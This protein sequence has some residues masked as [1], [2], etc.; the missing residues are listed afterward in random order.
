MADKLLKYSLLIIIIYYLYSCSETK[1]STVKEVKCVE[2]KYTPAELIKQKEVIK[3][4]RAISADWKADSSGC[5][6]IRRRKYFIKIFEGDELNVVPL[7]TVLFLLGS[8]TYIKKYS[9][10]RKDILYCYT[11]FNL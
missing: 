10:E 1:I 9:K 11:K 4:L 7:D 3:K 2:R 6:G 5:N 8:C